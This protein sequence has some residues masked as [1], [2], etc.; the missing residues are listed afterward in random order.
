LFIALRNSSVVAF[1]T[2]AMAGGRA[3]PGSVVGVG[4]ACRAAA[5]STRRDMSKFSLLTP[6]GGSVIMAIVTQE[7]VAAELFGG[8]GGVEILVVIVVVGLWWGCCEAL[9]E[10]DGLGGCRPAV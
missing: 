10:R 6:E 2:P 9:R 4:M 5:S 3:A 8:G 1:F 7:V